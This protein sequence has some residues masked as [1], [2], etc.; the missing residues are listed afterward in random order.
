MR[1]VEEFS[2]VVVLAMPGKVELGLAKGREKTARRM[3]ELPV[4]GPMSPSVTSRFKKCCEVARDCH[5]NVV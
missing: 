1:R 3:L 4:D 5:G 2:G